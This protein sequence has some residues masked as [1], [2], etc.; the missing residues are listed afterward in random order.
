M[1]CE[2]CGQEKPEPIKKTVWLNI[3]PDRGAMCWCWLS[4]EIADTNANTDR[5]AC[6]PVTYYESEGLEPNLVQRLILELYSNPIPT[7]G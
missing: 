1:K 6:I 4:K 7:A 3:Y 2:S 5:I